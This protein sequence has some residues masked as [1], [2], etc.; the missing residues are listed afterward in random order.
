MACA[1][2]LSPTNLGEGAREEVGDPDGH[3]AVKGVESE[4]DEKPPDTAEK[5]EDEG[6]PDVHR[7]QAHN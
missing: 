7:R 1:L 5:D 3:D 6:R 2:S 4:E